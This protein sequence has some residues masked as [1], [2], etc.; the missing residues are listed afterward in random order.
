MQVPEQVMHA[1]RSV[2]MA[3]RYAILCMRSRK[4]WANAVEAV[5]DAEEK[6]ALAKKECN[7]EFPKD[8][9]GL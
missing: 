9:P 8:M 7:F 4:K 5:K 1:L 6:L 3:Q 2:I